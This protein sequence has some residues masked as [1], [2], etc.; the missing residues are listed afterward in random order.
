MS[1]HF[2]GFSYINSYIFAVIISVFVGMVPRAH[3]S[4][5]ADWSMGT[6]NVAPKSN[7]YDCNCTSAQTE[8]T[9]GSHVSFK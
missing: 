8:E 3:G 2:R 7:N 5:V 6:V 4:Y 9:K 1:E